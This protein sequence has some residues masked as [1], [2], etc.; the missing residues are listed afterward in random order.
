A[1]ACL[2]ASGRRGTQKRGAPLRGAPLRGQTRRGRRVDD[3]EV[4]AHTEQELVDIAIFVV[5]EAG[6]DVHAGAG[7]KHAS[8]VDVE[9]VLV[10]VVVVVLDVLERRP[11]AEVARTATG[12]QGNTRGLVGTA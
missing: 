7:A 10:A 6:L 4:G 12:Q 11:P 1:V 8:Q 9:H 3:S 5:V 2:R